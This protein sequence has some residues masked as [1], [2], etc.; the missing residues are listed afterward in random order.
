ML[1]HLLRRIQVADLSFVLSKKQKMHRDS[2]CPPRGSQMLLSC[3]I[4]FNLQLLHDDCMAIKMKE[5][6]LL[7]APPPA[8]GIAINGMLNWHP[9][10]EEIFTNV[11]NI[12]RQQVSAHEQEELD[13]VTGTGDLAA[14]AQRLDAIHADAREQLM[15]RD[16]EDWAYAW[17]QTT[18]PLVADALGEL[19]VHS[20]EAARRLAAD[21]GQQAMLEGARDRQL[22]RI[23]GARAQWQQQVD[24]AAEQG[25]GER[26]CSWLEQGRG[27]FVP[28][29]EMDKQQTAVRSHAALSHWRSRLQQQPLE[30]LAECRS[31]S[32]G[33]LPAVESDR[34][35]LQE[36]EQ[37]AGRLASR[38]F[39]SASVADLRE[40]RP[41]QK[42]AVQLA[43]KAG[44]I[45]K[46]AEASALSH[47]S[48]PAAE[49]QCRWLERVDECP[50]D[51]DAQIR[52][53][54]DIATS[55]LPPQERCALLDRLQ[56]ALALPVDDRLSLSRALW[57]LYTSGAFGCPGD[58][59][60]LRTL[61]R[62]RRGAIALLSEKG[63][64][65]SA[66]W[67]RSLQHPFDRMVRFQPQPADNKLI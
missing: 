31:A 44:I 17:R 40:G 7:H 18:A 6:G 35:A 48:A 49:E 25:D 53:A 41:L 34:R 43:R 56:T 3:L 4:A 29:Q 30:A 64:V 16:V 10:G 60:S 32:A 1:P 59:Q 51:E 19:P 22:Q 21:A 47:V 23:D 9:A 2:N 12:V 15:D 55:S 5:W 14:F 26:A 13:C 54:L 45:D 57:G 66:D 39:L 63:A 11:G 28:E 67:L 20:R 8:P 27:V 52:L 46:Q 65:A 36:E 37:K 62:H 38:R 33:E 24:A 58:E 50:D 42:S 61:A